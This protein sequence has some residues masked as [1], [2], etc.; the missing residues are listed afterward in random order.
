MWIKAQYQCRAIATPHEGGTTTTAH[1]TCEIG[2]LDCNITNEHS[3]RH[4]AWKLWRELLPWHNVHSVHVHRVQWRD[5]AGRWQS[6]RISHI[7]QGADLRNESPAGA[8]VP[9]PACFDETKAA[10]ARWDREEV[11]AGRYGV[12]ATAA[13]WRDAETRPDWRPRLCAFMARVAIRRYMGADRVPDAATLKRHARQAL[14]ELGA[15]DYLTE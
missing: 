10:L 4:A 6:Q 7:F 11:A 9:A 14:R 1:E 15:P 12:A 3:A 8:D 5:T 13:I 2:T